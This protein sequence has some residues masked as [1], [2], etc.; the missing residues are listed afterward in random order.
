MGFLYKFVHYFPFPRGQGPV[1][2]YYQTGLEVVLKIA[3]DGSECLS[4][5]FL[6]DCRLEWECVHIDVGLYGWTREASS[7]SVTLQRKKGVRKIWD[8]M[9]WGKKKEG[10]TS[11]R[12]IFLGQAE[13][14]RQFSTRKLSN[15]KTNSRDTFFPVLGSGKS[16]HLLTRR[17]PSP[18]P[19]SKPFV[20]PEMEINHAP[21]GETV[22]R[23]HSPH[24]S[25]W[26]LWRTE[27]RSWEIGAS[28][29][30]GWYQHRR[31]ISI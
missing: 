21:R 29:L 10:A 18:C 26:A 15:Q 17:R 6:K 27:P 20:L 11:L 22:K 8:C 9:E 28:I 3:Q 31:F 12:T 13:K 5:V 2:S 7:Y 14:A 16:A 25:E 23:S 1:V 4:A 19:S 30:R 24:L